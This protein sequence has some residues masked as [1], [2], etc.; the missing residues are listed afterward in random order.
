M[1]PES[2]TDPY[3]GYL[4]HPFLKTIHMKKTIRRSENELV[5]R[6]CLSRSLL[7]DNRTPV[8]SVKL[9]MDFTE[10]S[11]IHYFCVINS[12]RN[13]FYISQPR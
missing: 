12:N 10:D 3:A 13:R 7:A 1:V 11:K 4:D 6:V 9:I 8:G 2:F 5:E